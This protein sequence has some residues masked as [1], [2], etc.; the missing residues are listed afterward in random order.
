ME[1]RLKICLDRSRGASLDI[2]LYRVD[3]VGFVWDDRTEEILYTLLPHSSRWREFWWKTHSVEAHARF[4]TCLQGSHEF[5]I[6]ESIVLFTGPKEVLYFPSYYEV[7]VL[8]AALFPRVR[9]VELFQLPLR[10][11]QWPFVNLTRLCLQELGSEFQLTLSQLAGLLSSSSSSLADLSLVASAPSQLDASSPSS[12]IL[13][14][15]R[16][17]RLESLSEVSHALSV[18]RL[19]RAPN[20]ERLIVRH[21]RNDDYSDAVSLIGFASTGYPSVTHLNIGMIELGFNMQGR[22]V[23][24]EIFRSLAGITE[25][26][27]YSLDDTGLDPSPKSTE[28]PV[29]ETP[30]SQSVLLPSL[31]SL[32]PIGIPYDIIHRVLSRR[33]EI[34][35]PISR[36]VL[37]PNTAQEQIREI[38]AF[39]DVVEYCEDEFDNLDIEMESEEE[40]WD[41]GI[42]DTYDGMS[43]FSESEDDFGEGDWL[44]DLY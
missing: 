15:L 28:R 4:L 14:S 19:V 17:F 40:E 18:M 31:S 20:L 12:V 10:W 16:S 34:G 42:Y 11:E 7:P 30:I 3:R 43:V 2:H 21:W 6:L 44:H 5:P 29:S 8:E 23:Y 26:T 38:T 9:N 41:D 27:V 1:E 22:V 36:L 13:P 32:R 39:V 24:E 33:K 25:L 37:H 35:H